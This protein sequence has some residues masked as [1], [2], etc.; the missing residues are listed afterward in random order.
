MF[1]FGLD[2]YTYKKSDYHLRRIIEYEFNQKINKS[3]QISHYVIVYRNGIVESMKLRKM[4]K[5]S[6]KIIEKII[7]K[8]NLVN[9][10]IG[11]IVNNYNSRA[12]GK[13]FI[14]Q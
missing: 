13:D 12:R 1:I 5:A 2:Q 6:K 14:E 11:N 9:D 10:I 4:N 3:M 7:K 8:D